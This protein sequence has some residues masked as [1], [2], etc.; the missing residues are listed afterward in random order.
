MYTIAGQQI[1]FFQL[2]SHWGVGSFILDEYS[3]GRSW[4]RNWSEQL[5]TK[6]QRD[7]LGKTHETVVEDAFLFVIS[8]NADGLLNRTWCVHCFSTSYPNHLGSYYLKLH[9]AT[10]LQWFLLCTLD[11]FIVNGWGCFHF[12]GFFIAQGNSPLLSRHY[13]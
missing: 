7:M 5:F 4:E 1:W 11:V 3:F 10:M 13:P 9:D 8:L 6:F 2:F 12:W